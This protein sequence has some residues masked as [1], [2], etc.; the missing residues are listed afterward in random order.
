MLMLR[1]RPLGFEAALT[2]APPIGICAFV[3]GNLSFHGLPAI[4]LTRWQLRSGLAEKSERRRIAGLASRNQPF[5]TRRLDSA[6]L[7]SRLAKG[8]PDLIPRVFQY[9][10]MT[11]ACK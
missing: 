10:L 1:L 7:Q 4:C 11:A 6:L 8:A 3:V 9:S 2:G 5:L